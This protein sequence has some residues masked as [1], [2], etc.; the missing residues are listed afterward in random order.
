[1]LIVMSATR[2]GSTAVTTG[3]TVIVTLLLALGPPA[4]LPS[5]K[6]QS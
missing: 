4:L 3:F 2:I 1:M 5:P 6:V